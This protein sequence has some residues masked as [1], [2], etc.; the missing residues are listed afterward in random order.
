MTKERVA[1]LVQDYADNCGVQAIKDALGT[2]GSSWQGDY[3]QGVYAICEGIADA[4]NEDVA[5]EVSTRNG[6]DEQ[7]RAK[8]NELIASYMLLL[9]SYRSYHPGETGAPDVLPLG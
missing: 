7:I 8:L 3:A 6:R 4:L 9:G 5:A 1:Q 2:G